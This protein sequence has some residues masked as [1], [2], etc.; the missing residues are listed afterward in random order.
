MD[1]MIQ[2]INISLGSGKKHSIQHDIITV[3]DRITSSID[4][5]DILIGVFL[6]KK[7]T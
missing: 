7:N 2:F 5:G 3:V 1:K 6:E 4:S